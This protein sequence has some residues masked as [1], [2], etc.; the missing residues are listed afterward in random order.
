M[1][2]RG[3]DNEGLGM[4]ESPVLPRY[5]RPRLAEPTSSLVHS[6]RTISTNL[7]TKVEQTLRHKSL[8]P[9]PIRAM[10]IRSDWLLRLASHSS[11]RQSRHATWL[12][13]TGADSASAEIAE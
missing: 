6:S 2:R 13:Q 4:S 8:R 11:E 12:S 1:R 7:P 3:K 5:R 10:W 9:Y